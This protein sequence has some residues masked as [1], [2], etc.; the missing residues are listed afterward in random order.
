MGKLIVNSHAEF[1]SSIGKEIGVS[2]YLQVTQKMINTFADATLDHQW[3][4]QLKN[5]VLKKNFPIHHPAK[6][7]LFEMNC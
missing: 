5:H 7:H 3:I 1:E 2:E 4:I 6:F